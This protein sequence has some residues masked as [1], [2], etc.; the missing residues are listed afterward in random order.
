MSDQKELERRYRRLL[1]W[2]SGE[3][4]R[5]QGEEI[6]SVL[7]ACARRGQ[8]RPGLVASG[9]L[10]RSGLWMRLRASPPWSVPTVRASSAFFEQKSISRAERKGV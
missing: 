9:D 4:Q 5:E 10:I 6:L 7:M 3:F 1:A 8:R 2:F